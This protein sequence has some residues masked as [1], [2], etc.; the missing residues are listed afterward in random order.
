M[1]GAFE[2]YAAEIA[3]MRDKSA[4]GLAQA[5]AM[6]STITQIM[7]DEVTDW[8]AVFYDRGQ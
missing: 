5:T 3:K 2:A 6:A 7:V 8:R 4:P 1:A